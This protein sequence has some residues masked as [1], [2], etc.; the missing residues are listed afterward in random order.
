MVHN[1]I[2]ADIDRHK[3]PR[4]IRLYISLERWWSDY[5]MARSC[6]FVWFIDVISMEVYGLLI[7]GVFGLCGGANNNNVLMHV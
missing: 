5:V 7:K 6:W 2:K 1:T 3:S 4:S